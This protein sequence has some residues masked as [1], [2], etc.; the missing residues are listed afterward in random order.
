MANYYI[1]PAS[2]CL[3]SFA[4]LIAWEAQQGSTLSPTSAS[5]YDYYEDNQEKDIL[6]CVEDSVPHHQPHHHAEEEL[7]RVGHGHLVNSGDK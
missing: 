5:E 7:H 1:F 6:T 4:W 2:C 3:A